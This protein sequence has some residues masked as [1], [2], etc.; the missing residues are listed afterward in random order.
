MEI[1]PLMHQFGF[2]K[3]FEMK[4]NKTLEEFYDEFD[5]FVANSDISLE[6]PSNK[7]SWIGHL[8]KAED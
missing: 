8:I 4:F 2:E 1:L 5:S 7:N 3:A 6:A